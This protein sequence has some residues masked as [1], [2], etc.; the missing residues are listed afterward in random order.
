[1][2]STKGPAEDLPEPEWPYGEEDGDLMVPQLLQF[3]LARDEQITQL[4]ED[5]MRNTTVMAL[6]RART[7]G[8]DNDYS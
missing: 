8:W 1:V 3:D 7:I 6:L 4:F 5:A 2:V